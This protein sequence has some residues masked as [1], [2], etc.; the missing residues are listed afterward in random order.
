MQK[1][2]RRKLQLARRSI[3][4]PLASR[5]LARRGVNGTGH[6]KSNGNAPNNIK[7]DMANTHHSEISPVPHG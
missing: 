7:I 2:A 5:S 3:S 6:A 4:A 1:T